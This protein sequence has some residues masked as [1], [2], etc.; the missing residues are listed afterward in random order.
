MTNFIRNIFPVILFL[1][2]LAIGG[3][4]KRHARHDSR[5]VISDS[6]M[7]RRPASVLMELR[8]IDPSGL[9][10]DHDRALH[11][12]LLTM[13]RAKC[14]ETVLPDS[15]LIA[16]AECFHREK[17]IL[18]EA[19]ARY[20][21]GWTLCQASDYQGAIWQ[22]LHAIDLT[23]EAADTFWMGRAHDLACEIY[24]ASYDS[25]NAAIEADKAALY[26]K[27]AG[28]EAFYNYALLSNVNALLT[29]EFRAENGVTARITIL[30]DSLIQ[31]AVT[32][33]DSVFAADCMMQKAFLCCRLGKFTSSEEIL[34]SMLRYNDEPS[35]VRNSM[36]MRVSIAASKGK[37]VKPYDDFTD[38]VPANRKDSINKLSVEMKYAVAQKDWRS[39]YLL[40]DSLSQFSAKILGERTYNST[41]EIKVRYNQAL[42][43]T[44]QKENI[45]TR[46]VSIY[47]AVFFS[48][49]LILAVSS[50]Y[51]IRRRNKRQK[52]RTMEEV[53]ALASDNEHMAGEIRVMRQ[54][55][56]E[57]YKEND[58]SLKREKKKTIDIL[59]RRNETL[60]NWIDAICNLAM[61]Y[62]G[63][64]S[65]TAS[66]NALYNKAISEIKKIK[67]DK[68]IRELEQNIEK[69]HHDVLS[70]MWEC[71]P[72]IMKENYRWIAMMICGLK[73]K[74]ICFL[75]DMKLQTFY[76]KRSRVRSYIE[77]SDIPDKDTFLRYFPDKKQN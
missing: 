27:K 58:D 25:H 22:A 50:N 32:N 2:I 10:D 67:S 47:T 39:A 20:Y 41:E 40:S 68:T 52:D 13:A 26:F 48:V 18:N 75:L 6:I 33:R 63:E 64:S 16:A 55:I 57:I 43:A 45:H 70:R 69:I 17:D 51:L 8:K 5:L 53:L 35:M 37:S 65:T 21:A 11:T 42:L 14:Y 36:N 49:L 54:R 76:V 29:P 66:K 24:L 23:H 3:C 56:N 34:D 46:H 61:E 59:E 44:Q 74:T 38:Y 19:K 7:N 71:F 12:L 72:K 1:A 73:P 30:L 31:A 9:P 60:G 77:K 62:Y 28:A 15:A 4:G